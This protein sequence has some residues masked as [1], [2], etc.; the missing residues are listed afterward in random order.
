LTEEFWD[1]VFLGQGSA[2]EVAKRIGVDPAALEEIRREFDYWY[3]LD[4]RNSG[5]D[6]IPNHLT[7][8]IFNHV[9]TSP[10]GRW[11]RG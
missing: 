5:K 6:L 2:A 10:W 11:P 8:F 3:P 9:A 7:F 4:S 1:Y